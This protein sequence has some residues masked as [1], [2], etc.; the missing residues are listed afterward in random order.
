MSCYWVFLSLGKRLKGL[1]AWASFMKGCMPRENIFIEVEIMLIMGWCCCCWAVPDPPFWG[2]PSCDGRKLEAVTA[3]G[4]ARAG[5]NEGVSCRKL[6]L[7]PPLPLVW[8]CCGTPTKLLVT[9][10]G[11]E[12]SEQDWTGWSDTTIFE[13]VREINNRSDI[14]LWRW[15]AYRKG[16]N[17]SLS[18]RDVHR[19]LVSSDSCVLRTLFPW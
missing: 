7:L 14:E 18:L 6:L 19:R 15:K 5:R 2:R 16:R 12:F 17:I 4:L 3:A 9:C 8:S 13:R 11:R 1:K 10:E